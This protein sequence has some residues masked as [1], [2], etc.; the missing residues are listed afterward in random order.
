MVVKSLR[1]NGLV[2]GDLGGGAEP[3]ERAGHPMIAARGEKTV[4]DGLGKHVGE[5]R[6]VLRLI[7]VGDE[8]ACEGGAQV[9]Q[10]ARGLVF[11]EGDDDD[12]ADDVGEARHPLGELLGPGDRLGAVGKEVAEELE[13]GLRAGGVADDLVAAETA[14]ARGRAKVA[15]HIPAELQ[16]VG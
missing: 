7:E 15:V 6:G 9:A 14:E 1:R 2:L 5:L 10:G 16:V 4:G 11:L 13:H 3:A 12:V 8:G